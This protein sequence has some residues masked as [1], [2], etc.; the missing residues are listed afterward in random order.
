MVAFASVEYKTDATIDLN[1]KKLLMKNDNDQTAI[2]EEI[3]R[4]QIE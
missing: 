4:G 3:I 1:S 2:G